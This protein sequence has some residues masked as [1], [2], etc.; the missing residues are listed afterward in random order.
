MS[1]TG[2]LKANKSIGIQLLNQFINF[3]YVPPVFI[4]LILIIG[5]FSFGILE[6]YT[7]IVLAISVSI[8]S[9]LF[10]SKLVDGRWRNIASEFE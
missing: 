10:L 5:H 2:I 3:R 7:A 6:G 9:E 4:S 1:E 8:V